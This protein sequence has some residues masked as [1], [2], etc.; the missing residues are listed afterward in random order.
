MCIEPSYLMYLFGSKGDNKSQYNVFRDSD[1]FLF[2]FYSNVRVNTQ[3][4]YV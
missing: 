4:R 3:E 1:S 2:F